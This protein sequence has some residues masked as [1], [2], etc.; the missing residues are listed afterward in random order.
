[1]AHYHHNVI[2][3]NQLENVVL[4]QHVTSVNNLDISPEVVQQVEQ[5]QV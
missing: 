3:K 1:M 5:E 2:W 4:N